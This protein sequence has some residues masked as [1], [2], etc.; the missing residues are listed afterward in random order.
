MGP[1]GAGSER[2]RHVLDKLKSRKLWIA[3]PGVI[4]GIQLIQAGSVQEG[5]IVLMGSILGYLLAQGYVD[6]QQVANVV[7]VVNEVAE[8]SREFDDEAGILR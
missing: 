8:D 3:V 6:A 4:S 1:V 2:D 7:H 5:V